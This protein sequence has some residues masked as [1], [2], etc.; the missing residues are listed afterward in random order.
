MTFG[1]VADSVDAH[2]RAD[3][4]FLCCAREAVEIR[5][6]DGEQIERTQLRAADWQ[7]NDMT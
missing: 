6:V 5:R 1:F 2:L 4:E 7:D 3:K